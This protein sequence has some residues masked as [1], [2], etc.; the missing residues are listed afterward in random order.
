M[1]II[2]QECFFK[3]LVCKFNNNNID[4]NKKDFKTTPTTIETTLHMTTATEIAKHC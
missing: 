2:G 4:D 1:Y 3:V